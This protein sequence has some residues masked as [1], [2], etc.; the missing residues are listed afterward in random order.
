[1]VNNVCLFGG[2]LF[3]SNVNSRC[4]AIIFAVKHTDNANIRILMTYDTKYL[5]MSSLLYIALSNNDILTI[6]ANETHHFSTLFW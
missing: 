5:Y 1:M 4:P 3:P 2:S 6:K